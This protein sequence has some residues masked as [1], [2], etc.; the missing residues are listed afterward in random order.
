[1]DPENLITKS[2]Q[3]LANNPDL[4]DILVELFKWGVG[5]FFLW[6]GA[7]RSWAVRQFLKLVQ[8]KVEETGVEGADSLKEAY[9]GWIPPSHGEELYKE[10]DRKIEKDLKHERKAVRQVAKIVPREWAIETRVKNRNESKRLNSK[11]GPK[12]TGR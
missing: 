2:L 9:G 10:A 8:R 5:A 4:L 7:D 12:G 3:F 1:M 11:R 6:L